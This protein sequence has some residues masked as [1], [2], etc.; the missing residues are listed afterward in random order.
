M[1][2]SMN[3]RGELPPPQDIAKQ[4]TEIK[5]AVQHLEQHMT[6]LWHVYKYPN[7]SMARIQQRHSKEDVTL[8]PLL[9]KQ[10]IAQA[11]SLLRIAASEIREP[12]PGVALLAFL[13]STFQRLKQDPNFDELQWTAY[14]GLHGAYELDVLRVQFN[15]QEQEGYQPSPLLAATQYV[16]RGFDVEEPELEETLCLLNGRPYIPFRYEDAA[17]I[18]PRKIYYPAG[19]VPGRVLTF[20]TMCRAIDEREWPDQV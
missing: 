4:I 17:L 9:R 18:Y 8:A 16:I 7:E 3:T 5:R 19:E 12:R 20:W 1:L 11:S 13:P 15:S 2:K 14:G 6:P 10:V